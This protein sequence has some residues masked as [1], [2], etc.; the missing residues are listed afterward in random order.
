MKFRRKIGLAF[1]LLTSL[2]VVT[3]TIG[4][5]FINRVLNAFGAVSFGIDSSGGD[6]A[7]LNRQ[8][9]RAALI[10]REIDYDKEID[11]ILQLRRE[12]TQ[13]VLDFDRSFNKIR[14]GIEDEM[15]LGT[16]ERFKEEEHE[17]EEKTNELIDVIIE[18][19]K[20]ENA[21]YRSLVE[22]EEKWRILVGAL[23]AAAKVIT[24]EVDADMESAGAAGVVGQRQ[25]Q[26]AT[27]GSLTILQQYL[28]E[29]RLKLEE[30][31]SIEEITRVSG[32]AQE[33]EVLHRRITILGADLTMADESDRMQALL[34]QVVTTYSSWSSGILG[35][36][37]LIELYREA[38]ALK[39]RTD[40]LIER[41][42]SEVQDTLRTLDTVVAMS[43]RLL[44]NGE[45]RGFITAAPIL[46]VATIGATTVLS[47]VLAIVLSHAIARP[48]KQ[49]IRATEA[50]REGIYSRQLEITSGD[51]FADLGGAFNRMVRE[52]NRSQAEIRSLN[53]GLEQRVQERTAELEQEIQQ[54][55]RAEEEMRQKQEQLIQADKLASLGV[56]VAGVAHEINNPNQA[57]ML[58]AQLVQKTW[59]DIR[60]VLDAYYDRAGDFLLGGVN[61]SQMRMDLSAHFKG[62][63]ES[64][65]RV[66]GI[67]QGLKEFA[68]QEKADMSKTVNLNLVV[69]SSLI[70]LDS[71]IRKATNNLEVKLLPKIPT[72][73]GN[74]Q[75]IEQVVVN[76]VQNACQATTERSRTISISTD[77]DI[78]RDQVVL[79]VSDQGEGIPL[80]NQR[81]I[82]DPFF[83]TK[84]ELGGTGLGL[85]V[86]S[87]IVRE[88]HG[89]LEVHSETG[90]GTNILVR[91]PVHVERNS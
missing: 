20:A 71:M 10:S 64:A 5:L 90:E 62:I 25:L 23:A 56:L 63:V 36:R 57:V 48:V 22:S 86:T 2:T 13:T 83:T 15:Y 53:A 58:G 74:A 47:L 19:L 76:L 45:D 72:F 40:I 79:E 30:Y 29:I 26:L 16:L 39:I 52:I 1:L 84:R 82:F 14:R 67:V 69:K 65:R 21:Y 17:L 61:Y 7:G 81:K 41:T 70:L 50:V 6:L 73:H 80:E 37:G 27:V 78:E 31:L 66:D 89:V 32:I 75:R 8:V 68:R 43:A 91:F 42:R 59:P 34:S 33:I 88:H 49:L 55:E 77:Y 11:D 3:G 51:E 85:S 60:T 12:L 28:L 9:H 18:D 54:R 38:V 44:A 4:L 87:S 24:E 35:E 46:L